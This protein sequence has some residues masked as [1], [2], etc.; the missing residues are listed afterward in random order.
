MAARF[1][2]YSNPKALPV[3]FDSLFISSDLNAIKYPTIRRAQ[4]SSL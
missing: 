2:E 1:G 4:P 3:H